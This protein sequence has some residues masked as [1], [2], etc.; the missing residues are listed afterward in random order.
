MDQEPGEGRPQRLSSEETRFQLEAKIARQ[1]AQAKRDLEF[2]RVAL[3]EARGLI[4]PE[5]AQA[6]RKRLEAEEAALAA[7]DEP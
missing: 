1:E 3:D 7:P 2:V 5:E 6:K 4:T